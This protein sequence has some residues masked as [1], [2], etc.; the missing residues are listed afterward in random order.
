MHAFCWQWDNA[1]PTLT[2]RNVSEAVI[3]QLKRRAKSAGRSLEAEVRLILEETS[4]R[5]T[6]DQLEVMASRIAAMTP[7]TPQTDSATIL[8]ESRE[9][10]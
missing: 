9:E 3:Q 2:V 6:T 4:R 5:P 10:L 1:M 8:R 7:N